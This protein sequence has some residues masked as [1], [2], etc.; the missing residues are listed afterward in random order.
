MNGMVEES[1]GEFKDTE[2]DL[3]DLLTIPKVSLTHE[4]LPVPQSP[5]R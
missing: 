3:I 4:R 1:R 5:V 2:I